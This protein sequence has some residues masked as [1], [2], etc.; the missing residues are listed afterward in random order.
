MNTTVM[1]N[2]GT[3]VQIADNYSAITIKNGEIRIEKPEREILTDEEIATR[4]GR[5]DDFPDISP[6]V[7]IR[8]GGMY[9]V[10]D[11]LNEYIAE[12]DSPSAYKEMASLYNEITDKIA[13][14]VKKEQ[15]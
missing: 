4:I 7:M 12:T 3:G 13:E 5:H 9:M 14:M 8:I 2:H 15:A 6:V 10:L 11:M 1:I